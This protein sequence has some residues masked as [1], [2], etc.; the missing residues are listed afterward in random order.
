MHKRLSKMVVGSG[1]V[2]GTLPSL[3]IVK[4]HLFP[5]R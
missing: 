2:S 5:I 3:L 4:R 1:I